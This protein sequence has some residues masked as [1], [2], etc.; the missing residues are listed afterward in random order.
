[1]QQV[2]EKEEITLTPRQEKI[3]TAEIRDRKSKPV[4]EIAR[5]LGINPAT[6]YRNLKKIN[7]PDWRERQKERLKGLG[8]L[9]LANIIYNIEKGN[10]DAGKD[11]MNKFAHLYTDQ[12]DIVGKMQGMSDDEL[13]KK[14]E[15]A[16]L[17]A[18]AQRKAK[19]LK[20]EGQALNQP[21]E[22]TDEHVE[23]SGDALTATAQE[24]QRELAR[25][26]RGSNRPDF[27]G[28]E[29]RE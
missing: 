2:I 7:V 14:I 8:D 26:S 19:E 9:V 28:E 24:T 25:I 1:M 5:K 6:Y 23:E 13:V 18:R 11:W 3:L 27:D 12:V 10:Y 17:T 20:A 15:T 29:Q 4:R 22:L 21:K 16:I